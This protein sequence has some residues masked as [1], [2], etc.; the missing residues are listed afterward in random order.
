MRGD[1]EEQ[2]KTG[3]QKEERSAK[4]GRTTTYECSLI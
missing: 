3:R 2:R 1:W 4:E